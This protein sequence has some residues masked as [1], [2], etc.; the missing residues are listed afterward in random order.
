MFRRKTKDGE[1]GALVRVIDSEDLAKAVLRVIDGSVK[2][3]PEESWRRF[4]L[5]KIVSLYEK[6]MDL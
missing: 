6:A 5:P 3:A 2:V 1:Y 4:E